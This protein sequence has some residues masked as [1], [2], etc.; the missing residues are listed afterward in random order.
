MN[1]DEL[2]Q[3]TADFARRVIR[4]VRPLMAD[5]GTKHPALQLL[6]AA[7]AIAANYRAA[8]ISRSH[9]EFAARIAVV[10]EEADESKLWIGFLNDLGAEPAEDLRALTKEAHELTAIFAASR[11]TSRRRERALSEGRSRTRQRPDDEMTR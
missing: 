9:R 3:R 5:L 4:F 11:R 6:R 7:T 1:A 10:L 2:R 8:C